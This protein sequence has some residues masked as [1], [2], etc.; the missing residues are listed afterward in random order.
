MQIEPKFEQEKQQNEELKNNEEPWWIMHF[1]GAVSEKGVGVEIWLL[2]PKNKIDC[3]SLYSYKLY[4]E[5]TNNVTKYEALIPGLNILKKLK[6]KK[7][8]IYGD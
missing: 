1:D 3:P 4:F 6:E 5:C 8:Y 7:V 2:P